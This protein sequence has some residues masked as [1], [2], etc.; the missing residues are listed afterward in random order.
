[1]TA[2]PTS[3][4]RREM[5]AAGQPQA[6]LA[7]DEGRR[8]TTAEMQAEFEVIGYAAPFVVVRRRS[9]GQVVNLEFVHS[10]RV[11]FGFVPDDGGHGGRTTASAPLADQ[12]GGALCCS[13][14]VPGAVTLMSRPLTVLTSFS[15]RST[16]R[17]LFTRSAER[18]LGR[19]PDC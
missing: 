2:D 14:P 8:W 7:A 17:T 19:R 13:W 18:Q 4:A 6:D 15:S 11:Y 10:P 5:I 3:Q 1:M 9:D 12:A 16:A